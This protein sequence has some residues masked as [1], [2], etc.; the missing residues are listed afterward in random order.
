ME[1]SDILARIA[2]TFGS[3]KSVHDTSRGRSIQHAGAPADADISST[4]FTGVSDHK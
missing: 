1:G 4:P 2:A 3:S